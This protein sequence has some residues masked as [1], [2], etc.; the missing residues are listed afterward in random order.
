MRLDKVARACAIGQIE[1]GRQ[2]KDVA[3]AMGVYKPTI[4]R[5][6]QCYVHTGSVED[7]PRSGQPRV[8]SQRTDRAIRL[9]HLRNRFCPAT[10]T[11]NAT[12]GRHRP[13]ISVHTVRRRLRD[14]GIRCRRPYY[15]ADLT[16]G[17][18]LRRLNW[19]AAHAR[20]RHNDWANILFTDECKVM[21]DSSNKRDHVYR[22]KGELFSDT[23]VREVN[24]WGRA[25]RMIW[26]GISF[27]VKLIWYSLTMV[28]EE[29]AVNVL[30]V[31]SQHSVT[32]MKFYTQ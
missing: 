31:S 12:P 21:V 5:L 17:H 18:R 29:V 7:C 13:R 27:R 28:L 30:V 22:R 15:G 20:W 1:A 11:A 10:E 24:R 19:A 23:C 16:R 8:R 3:A 25:S 4:T 9:R 26:A 32:F 2:L 6:S 14:A